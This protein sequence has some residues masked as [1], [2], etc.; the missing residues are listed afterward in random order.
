MN[1]R[2]LVQEATIFPSSFRYN[3]NI[4]LWTKNNSLD[5]F[6]NFVFDCTKL[7]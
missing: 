7:E 6:F 3:K 1:M 4:K 2:R 5:N